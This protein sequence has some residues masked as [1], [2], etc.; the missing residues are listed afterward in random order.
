MGV[1]RILICKEILNEL[2]FISIL[3]LLVEELKVQST[4]N[5]S[6]PVIVTHARDLFQ[7][8]VTTRDLLQLTHRC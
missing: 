2:D 1:L 7:A 6:V 5:K 8:F 4:F 3:K